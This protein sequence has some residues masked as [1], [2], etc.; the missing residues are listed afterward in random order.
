MPFSHVRNSYQPEQLEKLTEAFD[1]AWPQ[2]VLQW[3][4]DPHSTGTA[5]ATPSQF[6]RCVCMSRRVRARKIGADCAASFHHPT[7]GMISLLEVAFAAAAFGGALDFV[8]KQH[9]QDASKAKV[10]CPSPSARVKVVA[11]A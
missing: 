6:H 5:T 8:G 10:T 4:G 2:I 11:L 3:R 1:L 7:R 9:K